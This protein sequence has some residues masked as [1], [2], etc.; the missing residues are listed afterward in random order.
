[1]AEPISH[2]K[3]KLLFQATA[4]KLIPFKRKIP[5]VAIGPEIEVVCACV[6]GC[7]YVCM[8]VRQAEGGSF[9]LEKF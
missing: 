6:C 3:H 4:S 7:A 1:M 2:F 5:S 9:T 8:S